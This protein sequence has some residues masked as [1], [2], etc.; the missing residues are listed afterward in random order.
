MGMFR[1]FLRG[2]SRGASLW[3][4]PRRRSKRSQ[5]GD[6]EAIGDDFRKVMGL[7]CDKRHQQDI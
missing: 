5:R 1:T 6:F 4:T 3:W 2:M 7:K